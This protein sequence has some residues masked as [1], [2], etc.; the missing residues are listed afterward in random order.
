MELELN[1]VTERI[2]QIFTGLENTFTEKQQNDMKI[3]GFTFMETN[4]IEELHEKQGI[5]HRS[6]MDFD[7][8]EYG[9]QTREEREHSLW[10][11][12]AEIAANGTKVVDLKELRCYL[13]FNKS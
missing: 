4:Q 2:S 7:I 10:M 5:K 13:V 1:E 3:R 12:I 11:R 6:D 9:N 8:N